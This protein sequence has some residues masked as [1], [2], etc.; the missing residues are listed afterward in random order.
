MTFFGLQILQR[1]RM[2]PRKHSVFRGICDSFVETS[3]VFV[4]VE[5]RWLDDGE[6][7]FGGN[8]DVVPF[9]AM[10]DN[11]D[12]SRLMIAF[13]LNE[14][15]G[16][17]RIISV[18]YRNACTHSDGIHVV[19]QGIFTNVSAHTPTKANDLL[20]RQKPQRRKNIV[21]QRQRILS[22]EP[23]H[24]RVRNRY[25]RR[26]TVAGMPDP[27]GIGIIPLDSQE[28][29]HSVGNFVVI[30]CCRQGIMNSIVF[31][32]WPSVAAVSGYARTGNGLEEGHPRSMLRRGA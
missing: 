9:E 15:P 31:D 13:R 5:L 24:Q 20:Q 25:R 16:R 23:L 26:L 29:P 22:S 27:R 6:C 17:K 2:G 18:P 3:L 10:M 19:L 11:D 7:G 4:E 8:G 1:W 21:H 14:E 30:F 32:D 28:T 12:I